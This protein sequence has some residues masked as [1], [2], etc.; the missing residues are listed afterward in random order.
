MIG[1][2]DGSAVA[3]VAPLAAQLSDLGVPYGG[4]IA[5]AVVIVGVFNVGGIA[6]PM[7]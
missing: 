2:I 5:Q 1:E 7:E 3:L 6:D 4:T